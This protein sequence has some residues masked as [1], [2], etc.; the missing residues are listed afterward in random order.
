MFRLFMRIVFILF[1]Y[2]TIVM[3]GWQAAM[4][5]LSETVFGFEQ[6]ILT[7]NE[8]CNEMLQDLLNCE[9]LFEG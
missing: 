3:Q 2:M 4:A 8:Q 5:N 9:Q 7:M 1:V 6:R